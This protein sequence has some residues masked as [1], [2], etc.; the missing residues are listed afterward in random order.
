M[1]SQRGL[2]RAK[3]NEDEIY[4]RQKRKQEQE[5]RD[6]VFTPQK[7]AKILKGNYELQQSLNQALDN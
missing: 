3:K 2:K 4:D 1:P 7:K 5:E 6:K